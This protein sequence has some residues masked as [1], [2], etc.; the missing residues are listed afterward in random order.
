MRNHHNAMLLSTLARDHLAITEARR[1]R[2]IRRS[3]KT[4]WS[5][6]KDNKKYPCID[7]HVVEESQVFSVLF[8]FTLLVSQGHS[9]YD[10][11]AQCEGGMNVARCLLFVAC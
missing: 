3:F 8:R 2:R 1:H 6:L 4:L 11:L 5:L 9:Y 7:D 10:V